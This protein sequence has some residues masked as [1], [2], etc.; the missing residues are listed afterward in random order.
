MRKLLVIALTLLAT[1]AIAGDKGYWRN[2]SRL[3]P[4]PRDARVIPS[5]NE[6]RTL[7]VPQPNVFDKQ[8]YPQPVTNPNYQP[9]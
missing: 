7:Y 4:T 9:K 3:D 2:P 6:P 8:T 5:G 1:P